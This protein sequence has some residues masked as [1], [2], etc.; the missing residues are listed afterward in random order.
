MT[1]FLT[2]LADELRAAGLNVKEY[3]GWQTRARGSGGYSAQPLCVMWH[4][5]ASGASWDGQRDADYIAKGDPDAPLAN[6]YIDRTGAVW[7]L[8]AGATNT[9]GKGGPQSFSRGTVPV[10]GM[11]TRAVGVEMGNN[12]VGEAWPECQVNAMFAVA[13]AVNKRLGNQPTDVCTHNVWA[14][15]RKIDPA[16]AAAVQGA[17]KPRST[18]SSGTW[19]LDDIRAECVARASGTVAPT[20][21]PDPTPPTTDDWWTPFMASLPIVTPGASGPYVLRMQHLM[22][23]VGA[24]NEANTANYDGVMGNGTTNALN[25]WK[26]AIGGQADSMCDAWTWGA[27]MHTIDGVPTIRCG[28]TGDDVKRMQHLLAAAGFM[29]PAN[30]SNYDGN[31]GS[32][33]DGAKSRFD[34]SVGLGGS[35]TSCGPKSWQS[36]LN[37]NTW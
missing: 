28:D 35:D 34:A 25:N 33:T 23:A 27:L 4:H 18:N 17:W 2:W 12:G 32:G 19:S 22:C 6:L 9:N 36:L 14:P 20:P 16:T 24:M 8:A 30:V 10:D 15:T 31:W 29:N 7:V 5:T 13:N 21:P 37:G 11:N 26:T 3:A 1:I